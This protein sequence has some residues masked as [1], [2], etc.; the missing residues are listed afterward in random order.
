MEDSA[1]SRFAAEA[2]HAVVRKFFANLHKVVVDGDIPMKLYSYE[3][4][5]QSTLNIADQHEKGTR[6]LLDVQKKI[7]Q[8]MGEGLLDNFCRILRDENSTLTSL[9]QAIQGNSVTHDTRLR[10]YLGSH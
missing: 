5:D 10:S 4:I 2:A 8:S 9:V 3:L 6:I 1:E 7:S